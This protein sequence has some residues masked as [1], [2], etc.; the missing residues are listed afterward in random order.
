MN[1]VMR[2]NFD[3]CL[4]YKFQLIAQMLFKIFMKNYRF[5][6]NFQYRKK[7]QIVILFMEKCFIIFVKLYN[8]NV[9][10]L[11]IMFSWNWPRKLAVVND[12]S[13]MLRLNTLREIILGRKGWPLEIYSAEILLNFATRRKIISFNILYNMYAFVCTSVY[14]NH[15][16]TI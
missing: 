10:M 4:L 5:N 8:R 2:I 14:K 13:H 6:L 7:L 1:Y 11:T 16:E 3:R 9:A 15:I 12:K